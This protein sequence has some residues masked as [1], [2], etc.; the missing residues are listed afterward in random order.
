MRYFRAIGMIFPRLPLH[1]MEFEGIWGT[2]VS[3]K[4]Y[5]QG[6]YTMGFCPVHWTRVRRMWY[7]R[8]S[9]HCHCDFLPNARYLINGPPLSSWLISLSLL[10][11]LITL[12]Q[13]YLKLGFCTHLV[14]R[15]MPLLGMFAN[16]WLPLS[17]FDVWGRNGE[18]CNWWR[19]M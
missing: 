17:P 19:K 3:L 16:T 4:F 8:I 1:L 2:G 7:G 9:F 6:K 13:R 14:I 10:I 15:T 18:F 5:V 11:C 12:A